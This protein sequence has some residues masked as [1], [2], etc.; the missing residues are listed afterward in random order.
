MTLLELHSRLLI[1]KAFGMVRHGGHPAGAEGSEEDFS[2]KPWRAVELSEL[3]GPRSIS[4]WRAVSDTQLDP[5][6]DE[7][8]YCQACGRYAGGS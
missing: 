3:R 1:E 5:L 8:C 7:K 2:G 6:T 4:F